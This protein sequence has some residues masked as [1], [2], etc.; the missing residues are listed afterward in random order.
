MKRPSIRFLSIFAVG[1]SLAGLPGCGD[2]DSDEMP[3]DGVA[4][5]G[6]VVIERSEFEKWFQLI[7]RS[8]FLP[9]KAFAEAPPNPPSFSNCVA[10][11]RERAT[12]QR[13]RKLSDEQLR[14][15]CERE[16]VALKGE[17][18]GMVIQTEWVRQESADLG[19]A[20]SDAEIDRL[21]EEQKK[22]GFP[23][24]EAYENFLRDAGLTESDIRLRIRIDRLQEKLEQRTA[25]KISDED[26]ASYYEKND[27]RFRAPERRSFTYVLAKTEAGA[28]RA[29]RA[30]ESGE[31]WETVVKRYSIDPT[32]SEAHAI[33]SP[34]PEEGLEA[35][36]QALWQAGEG[37]IGGPVETRPGWYVFEVTKV[38]P[39]AHQPLAEVKETIAEDLREERREAARK[40]FESDYRSKTVCADGFKVPLCSNGPQEKPS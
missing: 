24:D 32:K 26:I 17:T 36:E 25:D 23:N 14:Q 2:D 38:T 15:R 21:L 16:Y 4:K 29:R 13:R 40:Q 3:P 1:L 34:E 5:V 37:D 8:P 35:L 39:A 7:V 31:S 22:N 30:V 28:A 27:A 12:P 20:V 33:K 9:G 6:D 19:L 18:M 11:K 10:A